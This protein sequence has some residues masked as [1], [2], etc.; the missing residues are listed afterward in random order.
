V[1]HIPLPGGHPAG[2]IARIFL[3]RNRRIRNGETYAYWSLMRTV[4]TAKGSRHELVA[5][6]GKAPGLD[7]DTRH[8]WE[9]LA[10]LL[11]GRNPGGTQ[12]ELGQPLP[13]A[14]PPLRWTQV[15]VGALRV[16]RV[17]DFGEVFL[18]LALWRR[19]GL[20]TLLREIRPTNPA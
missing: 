6:L 19:L 8:G 7:P 10:D 13:P 1:R 5:N 20:H 11:D 12:R 4:R 9:H 2:H 15:D 18:A 16:E 3:R 14:T 17:R